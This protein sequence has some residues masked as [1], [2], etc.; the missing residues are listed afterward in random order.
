MIEIFKG[1]SV[2]QG[3][4]RYSEGINSKIILNR[5]DRFG[6]RVETAAFSPS[7]DSS[8]RKDGFKIYVGT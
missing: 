7:R 8:T 3:Y 1:S 2:R 5:G 6:G 4:F